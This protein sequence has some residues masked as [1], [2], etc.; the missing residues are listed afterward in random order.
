VDGL[1]DHG[2]LGLDPLDQR[3]G[4]TGNASATDR[5]R[6]L[7]TQVRNAKTVLFQP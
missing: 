6:M 2:A 1:H 3:N 4:A 7:E 5:G